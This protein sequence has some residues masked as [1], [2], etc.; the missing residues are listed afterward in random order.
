MNN[1]T[2][3]LE[4]IR[5]A[6][7]LA[8]PSIKDLVFG[9]E[10]KCRMWNNRPEK[11]LIWKNGIFIE[12]I[13]G[14]NYV[15]FKKTGADFAYHEIKIIGRKIGLADVLLAIEKSKDIDILSFWQ[16]F[17]DYT[18]LDKSNFQMLYFL[19]SNYNLLKDDLTQQ[20]PETIRLIYKLLHD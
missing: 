13:N 8:N 1:T 7:I 15:L 20:S 4:K 2:Q 19:I 3:Q 9:C 16:R 14:N 18:H 11:K 12:E 5:E 6:C 17:A 10:V